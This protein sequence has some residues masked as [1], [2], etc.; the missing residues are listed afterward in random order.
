MAAFPSSWSMTRPYLF[1]LMII[2]TLSPPATADI[3]SFWDSGCVDPLAQTAISFTFP[4][5]FLETINFF[6]AFDADVRGKGQEPMTKA[7][8]WIGYEPY[9]NN[10][11]I[12]LNRTSEIAVRVGNLTGTPSGGNNGCDGVWGSECSKNMR[13]FFQQTLFDLVTLGEPFSDPLSTVIG[14]FHTNPPVISNCPP[15]FFENQH[16]PVDQF[17]IEIDTNKTPIIKTTGSAISPWFSWF[18]DNM[19][20]SEQAEQVA[21]GIISRTPSYGSAPPSNKYGIGI[22]LVCAQAPSPGSSGSDD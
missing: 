13:E 14:S 20:A 8:F 6:Y 21:V 18:I 1:L 10:S 11:V 7:A 17:G 3:C 16:F 12:D 19:T 5:L 2:A 4:P 15:Q 9:V 22:E